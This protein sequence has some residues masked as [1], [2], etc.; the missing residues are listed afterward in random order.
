MASKSNNGSPSVTVHSLTTPSCI[1]SV[2]DIDTDDRRS[3]VRVTS[4]RSVRAVKL[5]RHSV[6]LLLSTS[7]ILTVWLIAVFVFN[8]IVHPK[9]VHYSIDT[10]EY[11]VCELSANVVILSFS[12]YIYH[13]YIHHM[14]GESQSTD[15]TNFDLYAIL[16]LLWTLMLSLLYLIH[17]DY[18]LSVLQLVRILALIVPGYIHKYYIRYKVHSALD[19]HHYLGDVVVYKLVMIFFYAVQLFSNVIKV[20]HTAQIEKYEDLKYLRAMKG[21]NH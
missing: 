5:K 15:C 8:N 17:S 18:G 11:G 14:I 6:F 2:D 16:S 1:E 12:L 20:P 19:R 3:L 21:D 10:V 9:H 4:S 7:L 13:R